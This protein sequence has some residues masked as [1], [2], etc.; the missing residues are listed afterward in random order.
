MKFT[1]Y[2]D[3]PIIRSGYKGKFVWAIAN[4]DGRQDYAIVCTPGSSA[5]ER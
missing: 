3:I 1:A 4:Y 2:I 5:I